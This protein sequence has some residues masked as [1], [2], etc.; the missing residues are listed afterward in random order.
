ML[1]GSPLPLSTRAQAQKSLQSSRLLFIPKPQPNEE[2]IEG[3][4]LKE[5]CAKDREQLYTLAV[6]RKKLKLCFV[7]PINMQISSIRAM[8]CMLAKNTFA[9][10]LAPCAA[11][12]DV[13]PSI[14]TFSSQL[15][16]HATSIET[17]EPISGS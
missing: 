9:L 4:Y 11:L 16:L 5:R 3:R 17:N 15:V 8:Q 6:S 2:E 7:A 10:D 1:V 13:N 14:H 12:N